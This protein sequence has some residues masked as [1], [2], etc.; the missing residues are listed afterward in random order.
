MR[1]FPSYGQNCNFCLIRSRIV[2]NYIY[3]FSIPYSNIVNFQEI[4]TDIVY[5]NNKNM[6][7]MYFF[8]AI[9]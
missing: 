1:A 3:S 9:Y 4:S 5:N 6:M 8:S 7:L 2:K